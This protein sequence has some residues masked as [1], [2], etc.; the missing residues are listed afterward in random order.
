M[1]HAA[2]LSSE[3]RLGTGM[4]PGVSFIAGQRDTVSRTEKEQQPTDC[5]EY[6]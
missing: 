4:L 2:L 6:P 1:P 3:A 5:E